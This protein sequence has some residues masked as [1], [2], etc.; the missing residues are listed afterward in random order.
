MPVALTRPLRL[1]PPLAPPWVA[2][3]L[4][5]DAREG[6]EVEK[7]GVVVQTRG[8]GELLLV[9][10]SLPRAAAAEDIAFRNGVARCY[11]TAADILGSR[12]LHPVRI[13][14]Y[15][16]AIRRPG[17]DGFS[18]YEVFNAGRRQGYRGCYGEDESLGRVTSSAVGHRGPDLV[19]HVLASRERA[20][21][22][23]NPRQRPAYLYPA[24]YGP[25][26]P[27][28]CRA[29]RVE[30]GGLGS[31]R[32]RGLVAGTAS[33]VGEDSVHT[34][35]LSAQLRETFLNLAAVGAEVA[36]EPLNEKPDAGEL[37]AALARYRELRVYLVREDDA[38]T[39]A[40]A[41]RVAFP[42]LQRFDL[43]SAD[44]CRPE[45]LV[46]VEGIVGS[47]S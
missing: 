23:E 34:D 16:P 47:G 6:V 19:V 27:C 17:E 25:E 42:E 45:L 9:R 38:E 13:W 11:A 41:V 43:A 36:G 12:D 24:R 40:E 22:V 3:A 30:G 44:L 37:L 39:V 26:S 46:E 8:S 1:D 15:V 29:S 32:A 2:D 5:A 10:A 14:N 4:G 31:L 21:P 18:R 7:D 35:D 28:F 20:A 33:I